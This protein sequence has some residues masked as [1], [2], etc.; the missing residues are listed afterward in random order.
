MR[1]EHSQSARRRTVGLVVTGVLLGAFT[2]SPARAQQDPAAGKYHEVYQLA[3]APRAVRIAPTGIAHLQASTV[4][5]QSTYGLG[6]TLVVSGG[7]DKG[8]AVDQQYYVRRAQPPL[9][10]GLEKDPWWHVRTAG[11]VRIV[12]VHP[13]SALAT[14]VYGCD[15]MDKGDFLE[16]FELPVP[17]VPVDPPGRPDFSTPGQVLAGQDRRTAMGSRGFSVIDRGSNHGLKPGQHVT[18]FRRLSG[19][20]GV[21]VIAEGVAALVLTDSATV[22]VDRGQQAIYPGDLVAIHR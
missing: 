16:P 1:T 11:W 4:P 8:L 3:C 19:S 18:I 2:G 5:V 6:D 22:R 15:A 20:E 21:N 17:P 9:E 14:I 7:A 12:E 10:R 13:T